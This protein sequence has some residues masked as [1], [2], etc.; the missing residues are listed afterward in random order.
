MCSGPAFFRGPG[1]EKPEAGSCAGYQDRE[2]STSGWSEIIRIGPG[3]QWVLLP[4]PIL[5]PVY[6]GSTVG[7]DGVSAGGSFEP[8]LALMILLLIVSGL[9]FAS[10]TFS[11]S[12][13][14]TRPISRRDF[15]LSPSSS[16][17]MR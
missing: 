17:L 6:P 4:G 15:S 1:T 8:A 12:E 13:A 9:T 16:S 10:N 14:M 11:I 5:Y 7:A 3:R 2:T